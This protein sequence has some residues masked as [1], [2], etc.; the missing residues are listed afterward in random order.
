YYVAEGVRNYSQE[1]W[2]QITKGEGKLLVETYID[3]VVEYYVQSTES[4]NHA[5][6]EAACACIAELGS[7]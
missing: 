7:K 5:V 6:R 1:T 4:D 2:Q 3:H